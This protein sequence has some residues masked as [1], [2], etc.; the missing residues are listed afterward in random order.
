[1]IRRPP[2]STLF[3]YTTLFRSLLQ[4][5][6]EAQPLVRRQGRI[7]QLLLEPRDTRAQAQDLLLLLVCLAL[8][9]LDAHVL[10]C[11]RAERAE[12]QHGILDLRDRD[13]QDEV[14]ATAPARRVHVDGG[15][16]A[17]VA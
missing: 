12:P 4:L 3:P 15:D 1:M 8:E 13:A 5:V 16:V 6:L 7:L 17:A 14:G 9:V 11:H 10:R 2:R